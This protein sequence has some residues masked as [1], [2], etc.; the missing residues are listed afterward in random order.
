MGKGTAQAIEGEFGPELI[1]NRP[2]PVRGKL[3][4][5]LTSRCVALE[6]DRWLL[7][8]VVG[9]RDPLANDCVARVNDF[10]SRCAI[11][12]GDEPYTPGTILPLAFPEGGTPV[13]DAEAP[14][15]APLDGDQA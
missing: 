14:A 11:D 1:V 9:G 2:L 10:L 8:A 5:N 3:V 4:G 6:G 13:E 15:G 12:R 7:R